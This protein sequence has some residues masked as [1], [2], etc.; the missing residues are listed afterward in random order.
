ML[1]GNVVE[2]G[3]HRNQAD[4]G[5]DPA[6]EGEGRGHCR[7]ETLTKNVRCAAKWRHVRESVNLL[8]LCA[9]WIAPWEMCHPSSHMTL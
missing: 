3:E 4:G 2:T 1:S 7:L 9:T 5:M 6:E 8:V